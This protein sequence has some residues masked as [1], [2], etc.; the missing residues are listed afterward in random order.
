MFPKDFKYT[1]EHIWVKQEGDIAIIGIT[2]FGSEEMG[3]IVFVELP[4]I[5]KE[6]EQISEFASVETKNSVK[7]LNLPIG[8]EIADVNQDVV[9]SPFLVNESPY[10]DGW[11]VKVNIS[12]EK[13]IDDLLTDI[14][15]ERFLEG[16]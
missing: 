6:I 3:D 5:G 13:E 1:E 11:L 10:E 12:D 7:S 8:G 16:L 4:E 14:E 15:Y 9:D 2:S